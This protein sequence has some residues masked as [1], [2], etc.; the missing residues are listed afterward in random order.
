VRPCNET[1]TNRVFDV[2]CGEGESTNYVQSV[3]EK[4]I[5]LQQVNLSPAQKASRKLPI[6]EVTSGPVPV[7]SFG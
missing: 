3:Q 1:A 2:V 7:F 5:P 6:D 4:E